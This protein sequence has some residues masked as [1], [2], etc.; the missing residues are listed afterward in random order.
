MIK[1]KELEFHI[2]HGLIVREDYDPNIE[3][4]KCLR[5]N[6]LQCMNCLAKP[7]VL[8]KDDRFVP[9]PRTGYH[10][11][12]CCI[13]YSKCE[14]CEQIIQ[15]KTNIINCRGTK[16]YNNVCKSCWESKAYLDEY[17]LCSR[18]IICS[19]KNIYHCKEC[20]DSSFLRQFKIN[21]YISQKE[22]IWDNNRYGYLV[23]NCCNK[24]ICKECVV[25]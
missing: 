13:H 22:D 23:K 12:E 17:T 1:G 6:K 25:P 19:H 3:V 4:K 2:H 20:L 24:L 5:C 16:C 9:V 8:K 11:S 10:C 7:I 15:E 18:S 21:N 14:I